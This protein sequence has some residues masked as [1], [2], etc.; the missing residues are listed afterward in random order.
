M[1]T[2]CV[3]T[4]LGRQCLWLREHRP[5]RYQQKVKTHHMPNMR[6]E[7]NSIFFQTQF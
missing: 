1:E 7:K 6:A 4:D 2:G 5:Q 3:L